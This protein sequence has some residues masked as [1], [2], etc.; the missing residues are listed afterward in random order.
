MLQIYVN[1]SHVA[2]LHFLHFL[3]D[4]VVQSV[5]E[6]ERSHVVQVA[7]AVKQVAL[8]GSS[9]TLLRIPGLVVPIAVV[10]TAHRNG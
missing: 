9:R 2:L 6:T 8:K 4:N 3:L 7:I 5:F 10:P 1:P